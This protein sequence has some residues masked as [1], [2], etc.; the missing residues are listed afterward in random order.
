[1]VKIGLIGFGTVGQGIVLLL[2]ENSAH[3][4]EK[5]GVEIALA[6]IADI[7]VSKERNVKFDKAILTKDAGEIINDPSI[8]IIV[9]AMGGETKALEYVLSAIEKGKNVVTTNK[10]LI[11]KHGDKIISAARGKKVKVLFEGAVCGGV[12]I[13]NQLRTSLASNKIEEIYGIVNGTTNYI[14]TKMTDEGMEFAAA[15]KEAQKLGF[16]EA[17]PKNDIE[18]HDASYKAA[19]L[20]GAAFDVKI[21]WKDVYFEGISKVAQEDIRYAKEMGYVIKPFAVVKNY[22]DEIEVN[23]YPMLIHSAHPL[24]HVKEAFNAIYVKGNMLGEVMFYGRGAGAGPTASSAV[25]D[26][27]EIASSNT[28]AFYPKLKDVKLRS[29]KESENRYYIRLK[30]KDM[31]GVLAEISGAF[32]QKNVSIQSAL[33]KETIDNI[34]TIV[35]ITHRVKE[36][37]VLEALG[38]ISKLL[39]ISEI[40]NM[41][42]VGLE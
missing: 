28:G 4:K 40:G 7:D 15:L 14:L 10:E 19:I 41:V 34:A 1:M 33:Q 24:S 20:A 21:N 12:P 8:S 11:A 30:A 38:I 32:G 31:P 37:N 35:I 23:A 6:K 39:A 36:K 2:N 13:I 26:I 22:G 18:G 5:T 16:A 29:I 25:S 27:I 17:D 42:R 9:E 3:I